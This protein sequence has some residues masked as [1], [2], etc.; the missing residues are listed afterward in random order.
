MIMMTTMMI[1]TIANTTITPTIAPIT[2]AL[3]PPLSMR[4]YNQNAIIKLSKLTI[5]LV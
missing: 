5:I 1:A 2:T 4:Q 3:L